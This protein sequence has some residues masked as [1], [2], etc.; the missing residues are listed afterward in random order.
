M[1]INHNLSALNTYRNQQ[2]NNQSVANSINK[3]SSGMR[4]NQAGDDSAGLAIS[5]KMKGQIR[6]LEKAERNIADGIS[7]TQTAEAALGEIS[8]PNL[9]RLRELA[10]QAANDTLT[11][12]DRDLIQQEVGQIKN[13]INTIANN[14]TFNKIQLLNVPDEIE[15]EEVEGAPSLEKIVTVKAKERVTAGYIIVP[16]PPDPS[17]FE[18]TALFGTPSGAYWPDLNIVSP[19]GEKFGYEEQYLNNSGAVVDIT[20]TS[21]TSAKYTGYG[22]ADENMIFDNPI[23]GKWTI[24]IRNNGGTKDSSFQLKSNYLIYGGESSSTTDIITKYPNLN[25]QVGPNEGQNFKI[26]LSDVRTEALKIDGINL[27]SQSSS[28]QAIAVIDTAIELVS[29]ERSKFGTYQ[30]GLQHIERNVTNYKENLTASESRIRDLDMASEITKLSNNQII[31]QA[32]Q[33]MM[34]QA[35]QVTQGV[36]QLLK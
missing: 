29:S 10:V 18:I 13:G 1:I 14:T 21:S 5:E 3:L 24:E 28:N 31:L 15:T 34:S 17:S 33:A 2:Q 20:N 12:S 7:L 16:D 32:S 36:L 11:Q 30:N 9:I 27:T 4:I 22:S 23:S 26:D 25:L 6:G 8:N 19:N 35:N